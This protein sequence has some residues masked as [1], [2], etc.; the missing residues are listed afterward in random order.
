[1]IHFEQYKEDNK[2]NAAEDEDEDEEDETTPPLLSQDDR[3]F[4]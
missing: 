2:Y 4:I 1:L 3:N